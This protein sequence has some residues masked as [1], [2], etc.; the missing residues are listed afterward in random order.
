MLLN[1][2]GVKHGTDKATYHKYCDFY[3]KLLPKRTF[4]GRLL[5][6]GVM[7]GA[8]IRMW[9]EYYP[10]AEIVGIDTIDKSHLSI[11]GATLLQIDATDPD[12]LS[13]LGMFDIII[14]DGS[15]YT[16]D[17]QKSFEH[18]YLNQLNPKGLYI[19]ED[20]HTSLMPMYVNSKL[21]T[22]DY[23]KNAMI[24]HEFYHNKDN[25]KDSMTCVIKAGQL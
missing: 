21:N 6:I 18:L 11:E 8:S 25:P 20:L 13:E 2:I 9:A 15:H 7:D 22:I 10:K 12:A 19:L 24:E 1:D 17:Q 23:L 5:E 14:D 4:K 3:Q 16:A